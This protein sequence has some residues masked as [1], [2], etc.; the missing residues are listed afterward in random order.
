[1]LFPKSAKLLRKFADWLDGGIE[2]KHAFPEFNNM[3]FRA[4]ADNSRFTHAAFFRNRAAMD[5]FI[6]WRLQHHPD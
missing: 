1:M 4:V 3:Q 6:S 2:Q 5:D